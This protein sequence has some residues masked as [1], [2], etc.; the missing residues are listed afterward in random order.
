MMM[1]MSLSVAADGGGGVNDGAV[2]CH[3]ALG[4]LQ[5]LRLL[6]SHQNCTHHEYCLLKR[7]SHMSPPPFHHLP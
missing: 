7:E 6:Q 2:C 1:M 4:C 3:L 5:W